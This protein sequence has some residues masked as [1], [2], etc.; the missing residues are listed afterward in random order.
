[1]GIEVRRA[2]VPL[3]RDAIFGLGVQ[4]EMPQAV[5]GG[6]TSFAEDDVLLGAKD[7]NGVSLVED[8]ADI[9]A[10]GDDA[11]KVVGTMGTGLGTCD[12]ERVMATSG[13]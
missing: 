3:G 1:M 10:E 13:E 9:V 2:G 6:F 7:G 4:Q 12:G 11:H 5:T 8:F